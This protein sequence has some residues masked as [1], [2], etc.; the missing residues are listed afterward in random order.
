MV[1]CSLAGTPAAQLSKMLEVA[2]Q[3]IAAQRGCAKPGLH[4]LPGALGCADLRRVVG[5]GT[6]GHCLLSSWISDL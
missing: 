1:D 4:A 2:L 6:R 5:R 3:A